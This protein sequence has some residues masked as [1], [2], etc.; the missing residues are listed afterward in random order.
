VDKLVTV[1]DGFRASLHLRWCLESINGVAAEYVQPL[2][3]Q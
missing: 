3:L 1:L 2:F